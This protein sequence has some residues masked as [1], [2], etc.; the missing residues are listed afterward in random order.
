V[1]D[2][3]V[4]NSGHRQF[5]RLGT[6]RRQNSGII[7]IIAVGA[8]AGV[9]IIFGN[10]CGIGRIVFTIFVVPFAQIRIHIVFFLV[11]IVANHFARFFNLLGQ[12]GLLQPRHQSITEMLFVITNYDVLE[13]V[14]QVA[15]R[16]CI[17]QVLK[18]ERNEANEAKQKRYNK[19]KVVTNVSLL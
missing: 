17:F 10:I 3:C 7:D 12:D 8:S 15:K 9:K 14:G 11:V 6:N 18:N 1:Q 16:E 13:Q 5:G 2:L 19:S 4:L